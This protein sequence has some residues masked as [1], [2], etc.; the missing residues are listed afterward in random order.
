MI[1]AKENYKHNIGTRHYGRLPFVGT[2]SIG[3]STNATNCGTDECFLAKKTLLFKD[4]QFG[5][6]RFSQFGGTDALRLG[7]GPLGQPFL[8]NVRRPMKAFT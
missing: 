2:G 4:E 7:K 3:Q 5:Y 1:A 6:T 8:T